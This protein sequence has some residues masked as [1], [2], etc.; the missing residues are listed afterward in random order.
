MPNAHDYLQ[1]VPL[2]NLNLILI[3]GPE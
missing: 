1:D 2:L 3:V